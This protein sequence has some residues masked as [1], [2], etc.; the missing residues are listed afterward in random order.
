MS[1]LAPSSSTHANLRIV[2]IKWV[3]LA[4]G[5]AWHLAPAARARMVLAWPITRAA[6]GALVE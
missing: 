4:M 1:H 3:T 6:D 2:A 5:T